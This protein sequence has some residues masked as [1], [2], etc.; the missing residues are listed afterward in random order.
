MKTNLCTNQMRILSF[1]FQKRLI[2]DIGQFSQQTN[3]WRC[4]WANKQNKE[5]I[6]KVYRC[7]V[8]HKWQSFSRYCSSQTN[9]ISRN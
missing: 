5:M 9:Q 7:R 8:A 6:I 4:L 2:E 3:P 1:F